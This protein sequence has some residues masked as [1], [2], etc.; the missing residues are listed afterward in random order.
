VEEHPQLQL[1]QW[2]GILQLLILL[3][4]LCPLCQRNEAPRRAR[5]PGS[6]AFTALATVQQL[7]QLCDALMLEQFLNR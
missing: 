1:R 6:R 2:I 5:L 3:L 7:G 4:Q